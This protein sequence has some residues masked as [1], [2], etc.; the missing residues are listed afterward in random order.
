MGG[1]DIQSSDSGLVIGVLLVVVGSLLLF[2]KLNILH[3]LFELWP[4]ALIAIGVA[5]LL[6]DGEKAPRR[7]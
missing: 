2:D 1:Q 5:K 3:D 7:Q 6:E 4:A